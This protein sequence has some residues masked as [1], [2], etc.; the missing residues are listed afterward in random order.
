MLMW[1]PRPKTQTAKGIR[2]SVLLPAEVAKEVDR[3]AKRRRLSD[4][5]VLVELI[6]QGIEAYNQKEQAF[7]ELA[8][9]FRAAKDPGHIKRRGDELGRVVFG[10]KQ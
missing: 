10:G 5:Q 3:R 9:R 2:R 7:F 8:D 4:N 1:M 6:E